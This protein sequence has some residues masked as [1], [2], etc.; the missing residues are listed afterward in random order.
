MIPI[1]VAS[2]TGYAGRTFLSL[3]IAMK[4][5]DMG[6]TVG[7]MKPIGTV[8]VKS[9]TSVYDADALFI[10]EVLGLDEPLETITPFMQTYENQTLLYRGKQRTP[11]RM[12]SRHS[13]H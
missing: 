5:M 12:C 3:G 11:R 9:G 1:L 4:L 7:F 2:N 13:S 10:K 6:H 8:P